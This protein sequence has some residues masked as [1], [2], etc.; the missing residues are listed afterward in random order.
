MYLFLTEHLI[1]PRIFPI[2]S[3]KQNHTHALYKGI[4]SDRLPI[5]LGLDAFGGQSNPKKVAKKAGTVFGRSRACDQALR[6][7]AQ[8]HIICSLDKII[9]Q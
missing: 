8:G 4:C 9:C 6:E 1:L 2:P 3:I 7:G 5:L